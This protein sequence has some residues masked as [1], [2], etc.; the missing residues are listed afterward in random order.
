MTQPVLVGTS[1]APVSI[2]TSNAIHTPLSSLLIA[3][4]GATNMLLH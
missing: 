2:H 1:V 3:I 4:L